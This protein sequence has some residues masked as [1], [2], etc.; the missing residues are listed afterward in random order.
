M[1]D[2]TT[3]PSRA[4]TI[5]PQFEEPEFF[6]EQLVTWIKEHRQYWERSNISLEPSAPDGF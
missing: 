1:I 4:G 6:D 2:Q 3:A 5:S